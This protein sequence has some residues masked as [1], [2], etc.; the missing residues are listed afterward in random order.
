MI[1]NIYSLRE[2]TSFLT[3]NSIKLTKKRGQN[4]LL[5]KNIS[6]NI[7]NT[8][9]NSLE[10]SDHAIEIGGGLGSLTNHLVDIYGK[11]L[12]VVEYDKAL[13][14]YL[15]E[16]YENKINVVHSDILKFPLKNLFDEQNIKTKIDV[17]GNI[18]YN[19]TSPILEWL[20]YESYNKWRF[21]V[22][23]VQRDFANRLI[24]KEGEND[25]SALTV[26]SNF[27]SDIKLEFHVSKSVFFPKPNVDSSVI[28]LSPKNVDMSIVD[29]YKLISKTIFHNRRKTLR[30]NLLNSPY[31]KIEAEKIDTIFDT[32]SIP[33]KERGENIP[34]STITDIVRIIE[35][36]YDVI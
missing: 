36:K 3:E 4:F 10:R 21:A 31:I 16:K 25:Y 24:A 18:P 7:A 26:F 35:N 22:F 20:L 32:L 12:T 14:N 2:I 11:K 6:F 1:S 5:D 23:M 30:N 28:S 19:I 13:Y 33:A 34:I 29:T 27:L 8:I 17:Y 9:P 15:K